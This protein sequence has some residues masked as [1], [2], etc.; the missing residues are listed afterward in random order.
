MRR[1]RNLRPSL[2][3]LV[4]SPAIAPV[5]FALL[6]V[7]GIGSCV[8]SSPSWRGAPLVVISIDTL[9]ADRLPA[10]GY[11]EI[12][13]PSIDKLARDGVL[14]ESAFSHVPLTLPSHLSIFTGLLPHRHGVRANVG[15][16]FE[17]EAQPF[18]PDLMQQAGYRTG[19]AISA[20]P[21]SRSAGFGAGF[22]FFDDAEDFSTIQQMRPGGATLDK[23]LPWLRQQ[24][25]TPEPFFLFYHLF[26]P[27]LPY[28]PPTAFTSP[29]RSPY[30]AEV[31]ASDHLVGG[32]LNELTRLGLY[33]Q[34]IVVLLSDHGEGLGDHGE[35][36]HGMLLYREV[37]QVPLIVK[38]PNNVSASRRV[39]RTV[40]LTDVF[41][42]LLELLGLQA[43]EGLDGRSLVQLI[44]GEELDPSPRTL[45]AET[46]YPRLEMGWSELF[47][48]IGSEHHLID[49]PTPE[50]YDWRSDPREIQ[51][52]LD[53]SPTEEASGSE[54]KLSPDSR[55]VLGE[56]RQDLD[57]FDASFVPAGEISEESA[58]ALASLGY[59]GSSG[60]R[61]DPSV[62]PRDRILVYETY[63]SGQR[64]FTQGDWQQAEQHLR[65]TLEQDPEIIDAWLLLGSALDRLGRPGEALEAYLRGGPV[66]DR[67][68]E[69]AGEVLGLCRNLNRLYLCADHLAIFA[70]AQPTVPQIRYLQAQTLRELGRWDEA[71][72]VAEVALQIAP[73][74]PDAHYLRGSVLAGM[75]RLQEA[76]EDLKRAVDMTGEQHLPAMVDLAMVLAR[77]G[78][79][80]EARRLVE[81]ARFAAP[82]E[83][84]V[85]AAARAL[86]LE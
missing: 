18:L 75:E 28:D 83:P 4:V 14:F 19:A 58:A 69:I 11:D 8:G 30:D 22:D 15:Y 12:A 44:F 74:D 3:R 67:A 29:G 27:H 40:G 35:I 9:R 1:L 51:N 2:P 42:T 57:L 43:P 61:E 46:L 77:V 31:A 7:V 6:L 21:L 78:E 25:E 59:V 60:G 47:S 37:L 84:S 13:T 65:S 50:L 66:S 54:A 52:L 23:L 45:F 76:R 5:A 82:D 73:A 32:L 63:R 17:P 16:T 33:D 86:G 20:Y 55:R 24:A 70:D 56:L 53:G 64:A 38:L 62:S 41:P 81:L 39:T 79:T 10:Y 36:E 68:L 34:S 72:E 49:G 26:E 71:L 80:Q 48:A 85:R